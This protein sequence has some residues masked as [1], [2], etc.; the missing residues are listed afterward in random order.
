[1]QAQLDLAELALAD[2]LEEEVRAE[3]GDRAARV[4]RGVGDGGGVRVDVAEDGL[5][6]GVL[7]GR[8]RV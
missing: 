4:V 7:R 3:L 5:L 2:R 6:V 1:M 8:D